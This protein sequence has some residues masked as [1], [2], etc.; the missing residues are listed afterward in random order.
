MSATTLPALVRVAL[1]VLIGVFAVGTADAGL[2]TIAD[3][4]FEGVALSPGAF[5]SGTYAANSWNSYANAGIFRTTASQYPGGVPDGVNVAYS[6]SS[7]V[8]D[9]V[10]SATLAANTTY[11]LTVDVG[12]R[13]D[14]PHNDGF[15]I[16][17]LAGGVLLS[18]ASNSPTPANGTF[19]VATDAYTT[20]ASDP[21]LGQALE[22]KLLS[23][24]TGQTSFDNVKLD[25][26]AVPEPG[27]LALAGLG[28]A[29]TGLGRWRK[30]RVV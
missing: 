13:L 29:S 10:L 19:V 11:T 26:T 3:P 24:P 20:G 14:A 23:A 21:H 7:A 18:A 5:T 27:S 9:Q 16:E 22:I 12:S 4:S 1:A 25:A 30:K 15:T 28:A 8:I 2:L 6:S 17:L